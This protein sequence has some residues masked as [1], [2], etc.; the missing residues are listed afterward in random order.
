MNNFINKTKKK[1]HYLL[2]ISIAIF[3]NKLLQLLIKIKKHFFIEFMGLWV[4]LF[5]LI[6]NPQSSLAV[7]WVG[8]SKHV[9]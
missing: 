1:R 8:I 4:I 7:I 9:K 2:I 6:L 3:N 5:I